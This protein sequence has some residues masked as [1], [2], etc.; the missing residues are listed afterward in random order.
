[1]SEAKQRASDWAS[2]VQ[3]TLNCMEKCSQQCD[4]GEDVENVTDS[5]KKKKKY[6]KYP[7]FISKSAIEVCY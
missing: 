7:L 4:D 5:A 1:M 3:Q 6:L 2:Q